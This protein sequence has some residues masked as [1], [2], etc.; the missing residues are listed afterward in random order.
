M[1]FELVLSEGVKLRENWTRFTLD[2]PVP[3]LLHPAPMSASIPCLN[4]AC[5]AHRLF[6]SSRALNQHISHSQPCL[7]YAVS[8][9]MGANHGRT[10]YPSATALAAGTAGAEDVDEE[11]A[12]MVVD[13]DLY[14][15]QNG[16]ALT[17]EL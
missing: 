3:P 7:N 17:C 11:F 5:T 16:S 14:A 8:L 12:E 9:A 1:L 2:T 4:P 6:E 15:H 13:S 10:T